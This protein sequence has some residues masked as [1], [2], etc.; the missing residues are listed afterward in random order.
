MAFFKQKD[1]EIYEKALGWFWVVLF[2]SAVLY[3]RWLLVDMHTQ[4]ARLSEERERFRSEVNAIQDEN[5]K[6]YKEFQASIDE[7]LKNIR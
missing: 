5:E 6:F 2:I 4:T 1:N 7:A 3:L